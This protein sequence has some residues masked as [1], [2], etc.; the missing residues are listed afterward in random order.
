MNSDWLRL[1]GA[2]FYKKLDESPKP[3]AYNTEDGKTGETRMTQE[4][5]YLDMLTYKRPQGSNAQRKF[6]RRFLQPVFGQ[7]DSHG[8]YTY[9]IMNGDK[10]P[11]VAFMAH[12]DTVHIASGRQKPEVEGDYVFAPKG[13]E[14]LGADCTTG[15]Y[16]MLRMIEAGVPGVYVV[17]AAEEIGC[18]GSA[19]LVKSKP[20]WIKKVDV[21]IS[22]DRKGYESIITHQMGRRTCSEKFADS[23]SA[24]LDNAFTSDAT[25]SYTDSN[26]YVD[27]IPECTNLSVGY[28]NQHTN[29]EYQDIVFMECLIAALI[30]ADWSKLVI[31]RQPGSVEYDDD[32]GFGWGR[33]SISSH[34]LGYKG[35]KGHSY[36]QYGSWGDDMYAEEHGHPSEDYYEKLWGDPGEEVSLADVVRKYPMEVAEIL[37]SYGYN[38]L[39]LVDDVE[40]IAVKRNRT[41]GRMQT[42]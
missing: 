15:I 27:V 39:G 7:P 23:L 16:I 13:K 19:A 11:T 10:H 5:A 32:Y 40:D 8:N 33:G 12:H 26:E 42:R 37:E 4:S 9:I 17:H 34:S 1:V 6:N 38:A 20:D 21:A 25:G 14:C 35:P 18:I 36:T 2:S 41:I 30:D 3:V 29:R 28:F 22:F 24:I 31:D